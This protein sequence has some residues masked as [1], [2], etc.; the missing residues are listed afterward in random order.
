MT[1]IGEGT[2]RPAAAAEACRSPALFVGRAA[3]RDSRRRAVIELERDLVVEIARP[4]RPSGGSTAAVACSRG[5]RGIAVPPAVEEDQYPIVGRQMD[6]GTVAVCAR[7]VLPFAGAELA[8]EV[9]LRTFLKVFFCDLAEAFAEDNDA[10]PFGAFDA[11]A[12]LVF[13]ALAGGNDQCDDCLA[14]LGRAHLGVATEVADQLHAVEIAGHMQ[15]LPLSIL[16]GSSPAPR[17]RRSL[18]CGRRRP[19][20]GPP[21]PERRDWRGS[22]ATRERA[23]RRPP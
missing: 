1:I 18:G 9:N 12:A 13:P 5:S 19:G 16:S 8:F 22:A 7:L 11:V 4:A 2:N 17:R 20:S 3:R 23:S 15:F 10:V 21:A 14:G 6:L